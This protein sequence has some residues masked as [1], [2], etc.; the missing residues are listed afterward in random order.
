MI[1]SFRHKGLRRFHEENDISGIRTDQAERLRRLLSLLDQIQAP[2]EA[3][4]P[5]LHLHAL[6][7]DLRGFW[8]VTVS[9]NWRVIF[10]MVGPNRDKR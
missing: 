7:G 3:N 5:G 8:S 1:S 6:K 4:L 2:Q 9:G 10:T